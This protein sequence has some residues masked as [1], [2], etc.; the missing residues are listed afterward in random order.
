MEPVS[1]QDGTCESIVLVNGTVIKNPDPPVTGPII[2]NNISTSPPTV[3]TT[4]E[5]VSEYYC[6]SNGCGYYESGI[7]LDCDTDN[8]KIPDE[9]YDPRDPTME[10][11]DDPT[12][13]CGD[14]T[15]SIPAG[16][17]LRP[18]FTLNATG[19]SIADDYPNSDSDLSSLEGYEK[20]EGYE[21]GYWV[22][23]GVIY[24]EDEEEEYEEALE[25]KNGEDEEERE[26]IE[27]EEDMEKDGNR[28]DNDNDNDS[29][30]D[31]SCYNSGFNDGQNGPFSQ[32]TWDHCGDEEGGDDAY[33][34]GFIDGCI[35]V[36]GNTR[37][38]CE[39]ATDAG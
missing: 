36:E 27:W 33:Y 38:V 19:F 9:M 13:E 39:S 15:F 21:G 10:G 4:S 6:T 12:L 16:K 2:N 37:D 23:D 20:L 31:S 35:S 25:A 8:N 32:P 30:G 22:V 1:H 11:C 5:Q 17:I 29:S 26:D 34:E 14:P 7:C 18:T 28:N 24:T 3:N